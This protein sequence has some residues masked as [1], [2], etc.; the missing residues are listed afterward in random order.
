MNN[1]PRK[2]V[3]SI[4]LLAAFFATAC[5]KI[6]DE[7]YNEENFDLPDYALYDYIQ[8]QGDLSIFAGMLQSTGYDTILNA[9]QTFT[10]WAPTNDALAGVDI[11]NEALV[12]TI[13]QNHIARNR[14]STSNVMMES[15]L[16]LSGK[17]IE[18]DRMADGFRFGEKS[19][20]NSDIPATNGLVHTISNY[21][22]YVRNIWEYIG[23]G[24]TIDSLRTYMLSQTESVFRPDLS[25]E[26]EVNEDGNPVYD[27]VYVIS[28]V[29]LDKLGDLASEDTV[30]TVLLPNDNAWNLAYNKLQQYY[31]IPE[32]FGGATRKRDLIRWNI[33]KDIAFSGLVDEPALLDSAVSTSRT[34]FQNPAYLFEGANQVKLSNGLAYVTNE[35][36]F[37]DTVSWIHE[38][39]IE[40]ESTVGRSNVNSNIFGRSDNNA[41][42]SNKR[43]ILVEP[44]GTSN[45][46]L[47]SVTFSIPNTLSASYNIYCVFVPTAFSNPTDLLPMKPKFVLTY[48]RQTE[49]RTSRKNF[50]PEVSTTDPNG[51]TK[52][53]VGEFD[54]E[55]ANIID[56]DYSDVVVTFEVTSDVKIDQ[57]DTYNRSMRIDCIILEP[58]LK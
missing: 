5:T 17:H 4:L 7:H 55:F 45:I 41:G 15:I 22:P 23:S 36:A 38:I 49:G 26:I 48:L 44:T 34:I 13:V 3:L 33:V 47:S 50:I 12:K 9:S 40:A 21:V 18:L 6:W 56:E 8:S 28:N 19:M 20:V 42:V 11:A 54:F 32:I 24:E 31:N 14:Y 35:L 29:V 58:I 53:F 39:R 46:A 51:I 52:L 27:S 37:P 30:Y 57:T 43:Y 2:R 10:V 16:M 1:I 25:V